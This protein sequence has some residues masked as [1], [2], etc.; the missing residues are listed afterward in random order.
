MGNPPPDMCICCS[1][2][3]RCWARVPCGIAARK[4]AVRKRGAGAKVAAA[5]VG[6]IP[7]SIGERATADARRM[8]SPLVNPPRHT[9][10]P[11]PTTEVRRL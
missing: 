9:N 10:V 1:A 5:V 6:A 2:S 8:P 7:T 4:P 3:I 11:P